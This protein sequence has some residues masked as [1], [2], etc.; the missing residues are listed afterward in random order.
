MSEAS[1][2][3]AFRTLVKAHIAHAASN[4]HS[5]TSRTNATSNARNAFQTALNAYVKGTV[6]RDM[7][8][9][10][11]LNKNYVTNVNKNYLVSELLKNTN[12]GNLTPTT[13]LTKRIEKLG[14]FVSN[15]PQANGKRSIRTPVG[16]VRKGLRNLSG[17]AAKGLRELP[18]A[19]RKRVRQSVI[20]TRNQISMVREFGLKKKA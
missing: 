1:L 6:T 12:L 7:R 14:Y 5:T 4:N 11:L 18:G 17:A 20:Q 10:Y 16:V 2:K 3:Q 15:K 19:A 9:R 13:N 8:I